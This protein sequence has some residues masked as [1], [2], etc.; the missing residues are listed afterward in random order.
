MMPP[1]VNQ[2]ETQIANDH[3]SLKTLA[4]NF[5]A[6]VYAI[7]VDNMARYPIESNFYASVLDAEIEVMFA[8]TRSIYTF[9]RSA[10]DDGDAVSSNPSVHHAE[11]KG[12]TGEYAPAEV[13]IMAHRVALA[14]IK[15]LRLRQTVL[16][17]WPSQTLPVAL[18]SI[19]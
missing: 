15:R 8:P 17:L 11:K 4:P 3:S 7:R 6:R 10:E 13:Q 18:G 2:H 16:R 14:T 19:G 1:I 5:G 12:D 9:S